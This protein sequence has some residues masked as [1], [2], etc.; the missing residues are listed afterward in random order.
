MVRFLF[1]RSFYSSVNCY[2]IILNRKLR[3][4]FDITRYKILIQLVDIKIIY[5][6][7]SQRFL[8][9]LTVVTIIVTNNCRANNVRRENIVPERRKTKTYKNLFS[10]TVYRNIYNK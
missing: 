8:H 4:L 9:P 6:V 10:K 2:I 7:S 1:F 3:S 5:H